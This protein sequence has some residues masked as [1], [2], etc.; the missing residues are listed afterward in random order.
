MSA[1]IEAF[2]FPPV[3]FAFGAVFGSFLNVVILRHLSGESLMGRSHCV[4]CKK[5]LVWYEL[6]PVVSFSLQAARCR[7]CGESI[8]AQ[9]PIVELAAGLAAM[10]LFPNVLAYIAFLI[11][12][13]L[14]VIDLKSYFLPDFFVLLLTIVVLLTGSV[15]LSGLLVGSG[16]LFFLW[17]ITSGEGI[18]FGDV[19]LMIPL[20]LLFGSS[21]TM[22]LLA[23]AFMFGGAV[24]AYLLLT[25]QATRKTAIPFGPYLAGVAMVFLLFPTV[26]DLFLD[27]FSLA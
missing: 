3:L 16:F 2:A 22:L 10:L 1:M 27:F 12:L 7:S 24:G 25:K 15:S 17:V 8:S 14:F 4:H 5:T 19:K 26:I 23:L 11:L 6:I 18:G 9:Y 20:G 21:A 13:V